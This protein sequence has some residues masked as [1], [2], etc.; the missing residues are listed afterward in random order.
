MPEEGTQ[1]WEQLYEA[2]GFHREFDDDLALQDFC[3]ALCEPL[4][5]A[6][7]LVRERDDQLG[8]TVLFDPDEC[9]AEYLPYLAQFVGVVITPEMSEAQIRKEIAEPTGWKRGQADSVRL[10]V[11]RNLTG[12]DPLVII[13]PR[14]PEPGHH[15]VRTLLSET[16]D[17]ARTELLVRAALP[18]WE[19]LDYEA[20]EGVT[21]ADVAASTNWE[22]VAD[23]AA[24]FTSVQALAAILPDEL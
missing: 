1:L 7:D 11:Q 19:D 24:A 14:F 23:L 15:Y 21:V 2:T 4:Q 13:R 12:A 22:T 18:A 9:P 10:A 16:P 17:P 8:W 5:P 6:Y 20:I 3:K